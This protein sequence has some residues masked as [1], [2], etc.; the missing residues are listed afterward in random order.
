MKWSLRQR[1][2]WPRRWQAALAAIRGH[3]RVQLGAA[4][5]DSQAMAAMATPAVD[6]RPP[7]S[8][9]SSDFD[10]SLLIAPL[11]SSLQGLYDLLPVA[12]GVIGRD[13]RYL[14][15]NTAYAAIHA[16]TPEQIVGRAV[17]D[18]LPEAGR[19]LREDFRRFDAGQGTIER[20]LSRHGRHYLSAL[21][22]V[23]DGQG[24]V[25]AATSVLIDITARKR[26][27]QALEDARRHWQFHASHDHL[28]GLPNR[29]H[30]DDVLLAEAFRCS[31]TSSPLSVMM[32]DVDYFKRYNDDAGHQRGDDCLRAIASQLKQRMRRHGDLVGRYGGEEFIALLPGTDAAG[33][34]HVAQGVLEDVRQLGIAHPSSPHGHVTL[35]IGV[36]T[37]EEPGEPIQARCD[38][39]LGHA[40]RALYAAKAAGRDTVRIHPPP[41]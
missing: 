34:Y 15:A 22:P 13:G 24:A 3:R 12:L 7:A 32:I 20:E 38:A 5:A 29:R 17:A 11:A 31:R 25:Q 37:L 36:A 35:S 27:E 23:R 9:A 10:A 19:R 26:M 2:C 16:A 40:D 33:A 21:Q 1:R 8:H 14:A 4:A 39:L 30:I 41:P 18:Y 28:T 6:A